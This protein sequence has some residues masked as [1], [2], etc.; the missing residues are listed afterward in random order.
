[1]Q[2]DGDNFRSTL[3]EV[4]PHSLVSKQ[5]SMIVVFASALLTG[6]GDF[7]KFRSFFEGPHDEDYSS[8]N[9]AFGR[10]WAAWSE[11]WFFPQPPLVATSA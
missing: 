5:G 9:W 6:I 7:P 1:M 10:P 11:V 4:C 2:S 3:S 8:E